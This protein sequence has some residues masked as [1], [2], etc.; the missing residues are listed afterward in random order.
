MDPRLAEA[1][2]KFA[3][4]EISVF[5]RPAGSPID[6]F[7]PADPLTFSRLCTYLAVFRKDFPL[8]SY[9]DAVTEGRDDCGFDG[10]AVVLGDQVVA[11]PNE[12]EILAESCVALAEEGSEVPRPR[13]LFVQAKRS[14]LC[15]NNEVKLFGVN[16]L[17]FLTM[18]RRQWMA[19]KPNP[20]VMRWWEIYDRIR[21]VFNRS[22][23]P[24]V[25][26]T[27]LVF[28]FH[29]L[30]SE[31]KTRAESSRQ[32]AEIR[33][34]QQL[35]H[36]HARFTIWGAEELVLAIIHTK[37][38]ATNVLRGVSVV[39]LPPAPARGF[40]GYAPAS[41]ILAILPES[42][43]TLDESVFT[44]NVRS[45]LGFEPKQNPG[46]AGLAQ[47]LDSGCGNH[48]IL[49]HN[50][51]TIV[52]RDAQPAG[53]DLRLVDF[54][55]VNGAQTA[56]VLFEK[57]D[58]LKD[59]HLA[60][61]VVITGDDDLKNEVIRAANTQSPVDDYDMLSRLPFLR[62]LQEHFLSLDS[63]H[64]ERLWLQRRRGER[65]F[66][67]D[68]DRNRIVTPRQLLEAFAATVLAIPHAVH[69][70]PGKCL[71][72][73]RREKIF[74]PQHSFTVYRAMGC[75]LLAARQWAG[76]KPG[77]FWLDQ[78]D[79]P[80]HPS[81][82]PAR[83]QFLYA[84][85]LLADPGPESTQLNS[86][87]DAVEHR[88]GT[89]CQRLTDPDQSKALT[90]RAA[91]LVKSVFRKGSRSAQVSRVNFTDRIYALAVGKSGRSPQAAPKRKA[92][93]RFLRPML[94]R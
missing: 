90:T 74:A 53:N 35:G 21:Y 91:S 12:A 47:T 37:P 24:L 39:P 56:H 1:L 88:F 87:S 10:L 18:P 26:E 59:V 44:E 20:A 8:I 11:T 67:R 89:I 42:G 5:R 65:L 17:D 61:K 85:W 23:V 6:Q 80:S 69:T 40:V 77:V 73:V 50:G 92:I 48:V 71:E 81:A 4:N 13:V 19:Q 49:R 36:P 57:R 76:R 68:Y 3:R 93:G 7:D 83:H 45:F 51:I 33:M 38:E 86:G 29:G 62:R 72:L 64:P 14:P 60:L 63:A 34:Q 41:S 25:V 70:H 79:A 30:W 84:L 58:K 9:E 31:E 78:H 82:Y 2:Q 66:E 32:T 94:K 54:Q 75:L 46:A 28:A 22:S 52:A 55:I 27:D 43:D 16:A 15:S